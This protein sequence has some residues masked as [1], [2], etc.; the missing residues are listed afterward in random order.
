MSYRAFLTQSFLF[1]IGGSIF[2]LEVA[3][4]MPSFRAILG[5][6]PRSDLM[7]VE[8]AAV[9]YFHTVEKLSEDRY[10][11]GVRHGLWR[12][13]SGSPVTMSFVLRPRVALAHSVAEERVETTAASSELCSSSE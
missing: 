13:I 11:C 3:A 4:V 5:H 12:N 6:V 9:L 2:H 7:L 1:R 10:Q 8:G